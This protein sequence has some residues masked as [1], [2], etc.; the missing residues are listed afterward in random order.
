VKDNIITVKRKTTESEITVVLDCNKLKSDY[1]KRIKTPITFLNHMIEQIAWRAELNI[2]IDVKLDEFYLSHVVCEDV[3]I[4][5]G[6][7]VAEYMKNNADNGVMG[8][9]DG[10]GIID[11]A[12][13]RSVISFESRALF[14]FDHHGNTIP[15]ET[16]GMLS[17]DVETFLENFVQGAMCTLHVDLLKGR[18]GHHIWEAVYRSFGIALKRAMTLSESRKG[19]TSGVAGKV[20]FE[21]N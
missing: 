4:A 7:A 14:Q 16:E 5:F 8:F 21:I 3:G 10:I 19:L 17:E 20:E 18:N 12:M 1:R 15:A 13:A 6:K 9:G 11:E 2:E